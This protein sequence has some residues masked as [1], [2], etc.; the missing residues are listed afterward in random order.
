MILGLS[1]NSI[2]KKRYVQ[3][4]IVA[5]GIG[6]PSNKIFPIKRNFL[7]CILIKIVSAYLFL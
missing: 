6:G 1:I 4:H 3:V 5:L 7:I 2:K